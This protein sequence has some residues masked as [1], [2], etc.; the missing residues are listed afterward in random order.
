MELPQLWPVIGHGKLVLMAKSESKPQAVKQVRPMEFSEDELAGIKS[1]EDALALT[2]QA[3]GGQVASAEDIVG[4]GFTRLDNKDR[5]IG[6]PFIMVNWGFNA[7][8][9]YG[10]FAF[11][12]AVTKDGGKF[13]FTDGSVKSGVAQQLMSITD[14]TGLMGGVQVKTGLRKS[15]YPRCDDCNEIYGRRPEQC[16]KCGSKKIV[17]GRTYYLDI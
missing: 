11:V 9:E 16:S 5:L 8:G 13:R 6:V 2:A 4:D 12:R 1:W 17:T 10:E 7:E 15:E 3:M 14:R